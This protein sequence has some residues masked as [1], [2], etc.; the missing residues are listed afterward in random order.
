MFANVRTRRAPSLQTTTLMRGRGDRYRA[1]AEGLPLSLKSATHGRARY[2]IGRDEFCIDDGGWLIVNED[3]PYTIEITAPVPVDTFIIWFPRGW[4]EEVWRSATSPTDDLL[5][6]PNAD[7]A[8]R[9]EFFARYTPNESIVAPLLGELR[10]AAGVGKPMENAWLEERLRR[11]LAAMLASQRDLREWSARLPAL[12][13]ATREELWRRLNRARDFIH[14]RCDEPLALSDMARIAAMSPYH[15]LRMFCACF[16][17]TPHEWL[18]ACRIE[19]AKTLLAHTE[20]PVTEICFSVGYE[21]LG[22]FSTWFQRATGSSPRVWRQAHGVR[23]SI[24]NFREV[25]PP[26]NRLPSDSHP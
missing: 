11:L 10:C 17:L 1:Q 7:R 18:A 20:L 21:A 19:R 3:Q 9:T 2:T 5:S 25:S 23:T 13:A 15:F 8:A 6:Q 14:A 12:R 26:D 16:R 24:R 4:A 22:S